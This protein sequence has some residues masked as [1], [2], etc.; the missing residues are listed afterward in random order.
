MNE[1]KKLCLLLTNVE[2]MM[3]MSV[4]LGGCHRDD[5]FMCQSSVDAECW[6]GLEKDHNIG[7]ILE[8]L[9]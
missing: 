9:Q 7:V 2:G 6:S 8:F 3:D 1:K 4:T 5:G